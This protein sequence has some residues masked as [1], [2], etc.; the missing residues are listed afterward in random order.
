[1][2]QPFA[3]GIGCCT[4][5]AEAVL[6]W[7]SR[8]F[9]PCCHTQCAP[10]L[11]LACMIEGGMQPCTSGTLLGVAHGA[12]AVISSGDRKL[13]CLITH[14]DPMWDPD[15][16]VITQCAHNFMPTGCPSDQLNQFE[17]ELPALLDQLTH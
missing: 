16:I 1:M 4:C 9:E 10:Y 12:D 11:V 2:L 7:L 14:S 8:L 15:H 6:K 5:C 3:P 17:R 13:C